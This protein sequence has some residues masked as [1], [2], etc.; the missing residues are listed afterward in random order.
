MITKQ[1]ITKSYADG[2]FH[3]K[4]K[5]I[6]FANNKGVNCSNPTSSQDVATKYYCDQNRSVTNEPTSVGVLGFLGGLLG[7]SLS[8]LLTS[9]TS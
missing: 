3:Q 1:A 5:E 4:N 7:G 6:D 2:K 9:L 8:G